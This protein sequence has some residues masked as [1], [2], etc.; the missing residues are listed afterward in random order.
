MNKKIFRVVVVEDERM[1]ATDIASQVQQCADCYLVDYIARD[2]EMAL[3]WIRQNIPDIVITDIKMP[4]MNGIDLISILEQDYPQIKKIVISGYAE[5]E[6]AKKAIRQNV[7]NFLLKP[8]DLEE[9]RKTLSEIR[10]EFLLKTDGLFEETAHATQIAQDIRQY[11]IENYSRDIQITDIAS[12]LQYSPSYITK[13]FKEAF[14]LSPIQF[15]RNYRMD[16]AKQL[17]TSTDYSVM[18]VSKMVG[19]DD[20]F[21]FSRTFRK[22]WGVSPSEI[23]KEL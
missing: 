4:N 9:L 11:L 1:I 21:Y 10:R 19:I 20:Q 22:T 2:G 5:F 14:G 23:R 12:K 8:V 15:L 13:I 6:Y 18:Q 7:K 17:I 16:I 3:D